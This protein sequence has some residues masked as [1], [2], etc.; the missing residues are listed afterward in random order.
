MEKLLNSLRALRPLHLHS[1][2]MDRQARESKMRQASSFVLEVP[3][4]T[5]QGWGALQSI[6]SIFI[7]LDPLTNPIHGRWAAERGKAIPESRGLRRQGWRWQR[8]GSSPSG[9]AF[10]SGRWENCP[11]TR[12]SGTH[13]DPLWAFSSQACHLC[14]SVAPEL[15]SVLKKA[16][17][18]DREEGVNRLCHTKRATDS[19]IS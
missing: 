5:S 9:R 3:C 4:L 14:A 13:T 1:E 16:M 6:H 10:C 15:A 2:Q 18:Q 17:I 11:L 7:Q 8:W 12:W 19:G